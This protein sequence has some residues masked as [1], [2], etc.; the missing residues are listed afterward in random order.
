MLP[1]FTF[2]I[3]A[4]KDIYIAINVDIFSFIYT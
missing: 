2:Y 4:I 3:K 1:L